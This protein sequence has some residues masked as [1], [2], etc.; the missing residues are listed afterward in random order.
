MSARGDVRLPAVHVFDAVRLY[1]LALEQGKAG[2]RYHAV[3]EEG[4]ALRDI[5]D[6]IGAG[7]T[8]P[9][10]S[11]ASTDAQAYFGGFADL[12]QLDFAASGALT[13]DWLDWAPT[14]S[15]LL[16]DLRAMDYC[17]S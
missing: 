3:A 1:R 16:R 5:C 15:D 6:A 9:G 13:Q 10:M 14:G 12:V 17:L 4:V 2:A 8:L 11:I 7:L